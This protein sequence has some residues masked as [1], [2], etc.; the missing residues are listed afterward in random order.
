VEIDPQ[1]YLPWRALAVFSLTRSYEVET[2]GLAA[3]RMALQLNPGSPALMDLLGTTLM[4]IGKL[5]EALP[6]FLQADTIDPHQPAILIHLGQLYLAQGEKE[7]AIEVL[8]QA[9]EFARDSRLRD[10]A[11]NILKENNAVK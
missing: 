2:I 4:K 6:Y 3:A 7:K 8:Q 1:S 10:M 5:D 9:V 11:I